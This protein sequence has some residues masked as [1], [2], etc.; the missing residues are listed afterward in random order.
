MTYVRKDY[1]L[2]SE[3]IFPRINQDLL[4]VKVN[5]YSILNTYRQP[6]STGVLQYIS[7]CTPPPLSIVGGGFQRPPP[8]LRAWHRRPQR[9]H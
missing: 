9:G 8:S 6:V 7:N 4:W 2:Q 5:G 1:R 3:V